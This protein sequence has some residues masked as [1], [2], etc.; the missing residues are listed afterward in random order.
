MKNRTL[1]SIFIVAGTTI[2]AGMLAMPLATA[3]VGFGTTLMILIGLWALMCY[4]A[5]LLVEVYQHQPSN[6]GLGTLAKIYLGRWGQWIT[7]FSMLFLMYALTAAYISGAGELLASSISQWSG[8]SLPLSA[9]ILLFTLVAGGVVCIG[10]SSVDLFNRILFSGKVLMLVIMLAVMVPHI[11]RV[12]LLTLPLQQGLTL[13]ALPVILTSFGFHGSIPSIVHYMGGDSRK[14]R[15]IFLIGSVIPLIAY[16]FWQLVMLGSLSSSTFNAILADQAGLNGLMQ[17][18][19]TLVASPHV[20]LAVHLFADL[21]LATSFL[22]VALGLFDYLADL[23][24]RKNSIIGRAQ[25]GL[26][27][28]IPPLVFAL[29]YPQGFVMALGYAAIALAVLALL[30]PALLSWQ[31][32]K[33]HPEIRAT[34]GGAPVL[35]LVFTSGVA[36]ILIQ[37][38]MVAGWLPSIS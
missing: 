9:G 22:G 38:A 37:L 7:G 31:V 35:A 19:R 20:E 25:T 12:N 32:R 6:T 15:R 33:Q 2:G 3:G 18:I 5:L 4:S 28:F 36:I 13:S 16:I 29:F 10:T 17:A 14:L 21:A 8:Y 26:L 27:T 34:C 1:G 24:K 23:F 11:Q 30:I